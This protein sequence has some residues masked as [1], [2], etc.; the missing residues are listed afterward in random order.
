LQGEVAN[1]AKIQF[2]AAEVRKSLNP[3]EGRI[4]TLSLVASF[5]RC[6]KG[7]A[8]LSRKVLSKLDDLFKSKSR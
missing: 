7:K 5:Y 6:M 3:E 2:S 8:G 4:E 1:F